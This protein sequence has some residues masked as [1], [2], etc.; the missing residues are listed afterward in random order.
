SENSLPSHVWYHRRL[1][2]T[3]YYSS[4]NT[5]LEETRMTTALSTGSITRRGLFG[6]M[7]AA[8]GLALL[9]HVVA[10]EKNPA[11]QVADSA[12]SIKITELQTH[13]VQHKVYVELR[14]NQK[15]SGWGEVSALQ[16]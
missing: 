11:G 10:D 8:G 4:R 14:T 3:P 15:I 12:S 16:P 5:H 9:Q 2:H 7:G 6:A 1:N 13:R